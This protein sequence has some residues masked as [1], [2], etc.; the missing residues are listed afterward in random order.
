[1]KQSSSS[2][3][4]R[5]CSL[6]GKDSQKTPDVGLEHLGDEDTA[7]VDLGGEGVESSGMEFSVFCWSSVSSAGVQCLLK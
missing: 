5:G 1:M 4:S 6:N 2:L 7:G 3:N